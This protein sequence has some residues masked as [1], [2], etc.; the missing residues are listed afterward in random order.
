MTSAYVTYLYI[1]EIQTIKLFTPE[2]AFNGHSRSF[3]ES[4]FSRSLV[5]SIGDRKS[6]LHLFLIKTKT[7]EITFKKLGRSRSLAMA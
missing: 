2:M 1:F 5:L 4:S 7:A 3:A 6:S